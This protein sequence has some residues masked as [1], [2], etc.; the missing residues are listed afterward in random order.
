[1][2]WPDV[3]AADV[4]DPEKE[5]PSAISLSVPLAQGT[6]GSGCME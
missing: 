3:S 2:N 4:L 5:N 6:P 1:M